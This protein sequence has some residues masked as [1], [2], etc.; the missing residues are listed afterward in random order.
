MDR[1]IN[2]S[3]LLL[4]LQP[5]TS[6]VYQVRCKTDILTH[7]LFSL[8]ST[9]PDGA[10]K[11]SSEVVLMIENQQCQNDS[12]TMSCSAPNCF[13]FVLNLGPDQSFPCIDAILSLSHTY[14]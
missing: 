12:V 4:L 14:C 10:V 11:V 6:R 9:S 13:D 3:Y 2:V 8:P 1:T 5:Y 7:S